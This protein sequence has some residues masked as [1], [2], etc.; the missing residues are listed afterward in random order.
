MRQ[1]AVRHEAELARV[2]MEV[3]EVADV[4]RASLREAERREARAAEKAVGEMEGREAEGRGKAR[5]VWE[6]VSVMQAEA[7][8]EQVQDPRTGQLDERRGA[9]VGNVKVAQLDE[10]EA[11]VNKVKVAQPDEHKA[12][13]NEIEVAQVNE[14]REALVSEVMVA[15]VQPLKGKVGQKTAAGKGDSER[16]PVGGSGFERGRSKRSKRGV[17]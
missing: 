1:L 4:L 7:L 12:E 11:E 2:A 17:R 8:V 16:L 3:D 5:T 6:V 9:E 10:Q 15:Q 14:Q 13:V